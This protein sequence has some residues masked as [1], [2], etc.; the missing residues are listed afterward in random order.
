MCKQASERPRT[1]SRQASEQNQASNRY[2][3]LS[4]ITL[5]TC[6]CVVFYSAPFSPPTASAAAVGGSA[7]REDC[8]SPGWGWNG[9]RRGVVACV[10]VAEGFAVVAA[11]DLFY[12]EAVS[13]AARC[14]ALYRTESPLT[15]MYRTALHRITPHRTA[16]HSNVPQYAAPARNTPQITAGHPTQSNETQHIVPY[17]NA[18]HCT[19]VQGRNL[20]QCTATQGTTLHRTLR[21]CAAIY[22]IAMH[23]S[24]G[25]LRIF[26]GWVRFLVVRLLYKTNP[27]T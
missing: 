12:K 14:T 6:L 9:A 24:I 22:R 21:Y 23:R 16:P 4:A 19:A 11:G 1:R 10:F 13:R 3:C 25:S 17:R 15:T 2:F 8:F 5:L 26:F 7:D 18:L 20:Q 27:N